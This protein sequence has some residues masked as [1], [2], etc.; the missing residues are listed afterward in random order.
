MRAPH[1]GQRGRARTPAPPA[2]AFARARGAR[3]SACGRIWRSDSA[4][5]AR[6]SKVES[7]CSFTRKWTRAG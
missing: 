1:G 6:H 4:A 7:R 3:A 2:P 5:T